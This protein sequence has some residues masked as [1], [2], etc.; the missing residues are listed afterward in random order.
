MKFKEPVQIQCPSCERRS[1]VRFKWL[2]EEG[3]RCP[4]C[5]GSFAPLQER[6]R[7]MIREFGTYNHEI[8]FIMEIERKFGISISDDDISRIFTARELEQFVAEKS[9]RSNTEIWTGLVACSAEALGIS[10]LTRETDVLPVI[11]RS[12]IVAAPAKKT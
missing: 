12:R 3:Q 2:M 6:V 5:H 8:R 11:R 10:E 9:K 7:Q 4:E 1:G